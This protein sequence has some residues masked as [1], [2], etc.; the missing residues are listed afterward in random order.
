M[1]GY[2]AALALL[3]LLALGGWAGWAMLHG[4]LDKERV[5]NAIAI[6][7][8]E[9]AP[10]AVEVAEPSASAPPAVKAEDSYAEE[11][12]GDAQME[13]EILQHEA[14]RIRAEL[15]QR[16]ALN[17][18]ILLKVQTEREALKADKA[19]LQN[20]Q[21]ALV[22]RQ[23]E[24]RQ[25]VRDEGFEKQVA[26]FE[27]LSPKVA[28]QH[29]LGM[30]DPDGAARILMA[31]DADRARKIVEAAKRGPELTRMQVILQRVREAAP[32]AIAARTDNG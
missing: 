13:I 30:N 14:K 27:N 8:G 18:S 22:S 25:Q 7:R 32:P 16:L 15:D 6:L 2:A 20:A 23:E 9:A 29:L 3:N 12:V 24:E 26:I 17:N 10:A 1:Y 4:G 19:A 28:V 5:L 31:L 21:Q 11:L